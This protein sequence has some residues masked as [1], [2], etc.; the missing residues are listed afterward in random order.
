MFF[1]T[2]V[3]SSS[4]TEWLR[5]NGYSTDFELL[6]EE[7]INKQLEHFYPQVRSC[8]GEILSEN[9]LFGIRAG[10]SRHLRNP[11]YKRDFNLRTTLSFASSNR[12][13]ESVISEN[14]R[15]GINVTK[16]FSVISVGDL[17]KIKSADSFDQF[18]PKELQEKV[19][20]DIQ[21]YF[22]IKGPDRLRELQKDSFVFQKKDDGLEYAEMKCDRI[23]TIYQGGSGEEQ[24]TLQMHSVDSNSCPVKSLKQYIS[25]LDRNCMSFFNFPI[26]RLNFDPHREQTWYRKYPLGRKKLKEMTKQISKRLGLSKTYTNHSICT[27]VHH[28][29]SRGSRYKL[30]T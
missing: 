12:I 5:Q 29:S 17:E 2:H 19:F 24:P 6:P 18:N 4:P 20:L 28:F 11:P 21:F 25:H 13:L 27:T 30:Y 26:E 3:C 15:R 8:K 10:I 16:P 14:K 1:S 7:M 23:T 9:S 22:S